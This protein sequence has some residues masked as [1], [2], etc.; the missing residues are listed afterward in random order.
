VW[1]GEP[2]AR[3]RHP[4]GTIPHNAG[5]AGSSPA[6]AIIEV[7]GVIDIRDHDDVAMPRSTREEL[8]RI[9]CPRLRAA[10]TQLPTREIDGRASRST[11][12][13]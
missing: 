12:G 3:S 8:E 1:S 7:V 2:V 10:R 5:V 11:S 13:S 4:Y 6:P 9:A